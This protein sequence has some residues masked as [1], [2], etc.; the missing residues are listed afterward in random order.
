[1]NATPSRRA[2][3]RGRINEI[4]RQRPPGAAGEM[5]FHEDCTQ[6]GDCARACPEGIIR[7][8]DK[9]LPILDVSN[10]ACTFCNDCVTACEAGALIA[11]RPF[12][13][14]AS[15][16]ANCLSLN[17]VQC[18]ACQDHCDEGAIRF[19][20]QLGGS[21]QPIFDTDACTGCGG[22]VAPCPV[23]AIAFTHIPTDTPVTET[24][25]RPC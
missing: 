24:E 19:Q 7:R 16:A 4:P 12:P 17:G 10:G 5:A 9:G 20:L 11:E 1:M 22:C 15:A 8:D 2:F 13:W 23:G 3:L 14:R 21:A 6:C 18:R 25:A